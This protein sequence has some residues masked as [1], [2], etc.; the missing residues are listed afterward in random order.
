MTAIAI[1]ISRAGFGEFNAAI[2]IQRAQCVLQNSWK[3]P[4]RLTVSVFGSYRRVA[5]LA[6]RE[7]AARACQEI[8]LLPEQIPDS[9]PPT[10]SLARA[11][12]F[13]T[14][15]THTVPKTVHDREF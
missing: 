4:E 9:D 1:L 13:A 11:F 15:D 10:G 12:S 6:E 14:R 7:T 3:L 8:V 5:P 2:K